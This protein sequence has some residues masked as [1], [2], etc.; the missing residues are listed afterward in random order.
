MAEFDE[1]IVVVT[2]AAGGIGS[3]ICDRFAGE[4]ARVIS[5]DKNAEWLDLLRERLQAKGHDTQTVT[6]DCSDYGAVKQA[7]E[8]IEREHGKIDVLVNN[9]GQSAREKQTDFMASDPELWDWLI[10]TNLRPTLNWSRAAATGMQERGE[11]KIVN[12]ASESAVFGD[13]KLVDYAAA[14]GGVLGFTRGLAREL[15]PFGINVNAISPGVT[16]TRAVIE[17]VPKEIVDAAM[18]QVPRGKMCEPEDMA[19]VIRFLAT[20]DAR[21]I[22][23]QNIIVS[24]GRTM[25]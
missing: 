4:G 15:A 18:A 10:N 3:A 17:G 13:P 9:C 19:A 16:R 11:G 2:G 21:G 12:V 14:K 6:L 5:V 22:V 7:A 24:G 23:G 25:N 1:K 8:A 20:E